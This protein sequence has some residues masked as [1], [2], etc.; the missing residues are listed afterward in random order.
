[1]NTQFMQLP[2]RA[3]L[4][5]AFDPFPTNFSPILHQLS[6]NFGLQLLQQL[7]ILVSNNNFPNF[8][9]D[10]HLL[11]QQAVTITVFV[12]N[13]CDNIQMNPWPC[14]LAITW[15]IKHR[16]AA[17]LSRTILNH[18]FDDISS[19]FDP[20]LL[21]RRCFTDSRHWFSCVFNQS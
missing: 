8:A 14:F 18:F 17:S 6:F 21:F 20:F 2:S 16:R 9:S 4:E 19:I 1:M 13:N 12:W 15:F 7:P 11:L 3:I 5:P 10:F